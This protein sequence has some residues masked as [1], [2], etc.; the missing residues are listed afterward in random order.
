MKKWLTKID[1]HKQS[2]F[3]FKWHWL[4]ILCIL[5]ASVYLTI[6]WKDVLE[7]AL[8]DNI[9]VYL[10]NYITHEMMPA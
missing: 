5:A 6:H 7:K 9:F 4:V 2:F 8:L 1:V 10:T 3:F